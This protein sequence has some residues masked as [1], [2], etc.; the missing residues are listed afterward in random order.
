[1]SN[2]ACALTARLIALRAEQEKGQNILADMARE[3]QQMREQLLRIA[4]AIQVLEELL[5]AQVNPETADQSGD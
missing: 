4:G 3:E 5:E 2:E 1:M